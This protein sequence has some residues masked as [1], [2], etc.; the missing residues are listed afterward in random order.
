MCFVIGNGRARSSI[1]GVPSEKRRPGPAD[2]CVQP[3]DSCPDCATSEPLPFSKIPT[4]AATTLPRRPAIAAATPSAAVRISQLLR[5][6]HART[7]SVSQSCLARAMTYPRRMARARTFLD[8]RL[9]D[10]ARLDFAWLMTARRLRQSARVIKAAIEAD[11]RRHELSGS[12]ASGVSLRDDPFPNLGL[13]PTY[14][15]LAGL[16]LE[17][18]AKGLIAHKHP[19]LI[20]DEGFSRDWP[21]HHKLVE[22]FV[23]AG[24]RLTWKEKRLLSRVRPLR[25]VGR[26]VRRTPGLSPRSAGLSSSRRSRPALALHVRSER[27]APAVRGLLYRDRGCCL[28]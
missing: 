16:A 24:A 17:N 3:R 12:S 20:T 22:L 1:R 10:T 21:R 9:A 25:H 27:R 8:E 15:L 2:P 14:F 23:L 7:L 19:E 11:E 26:K 6:N 5:R 13:W 4:A 28:D 18:L